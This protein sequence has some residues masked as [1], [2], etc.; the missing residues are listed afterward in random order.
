MRLSDRLQNENVILREQVDQ[1]I[2]PALEI[3]QLRRCMNDLVSVLAL[4]AAWRGREPAGI[5]ATF[6]DSLMGMLTLDFFYARVIVETDEKPL[7]VLRAGPSH[8]TGEIAESLGDWLKEDQIDRPSE[9][10]RKIGGK[11]ISIFTMRMGEKGDHGFIVAGSQR[12]GFPE[13][14]ERLVLNVAANQTAAALQQALS[15]E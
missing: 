2:D 12:A 7:E 8:R 13:Q 1:P 15:P 9:T 6:V 3:R 14:T 11:E 5:I 10:W 4:P